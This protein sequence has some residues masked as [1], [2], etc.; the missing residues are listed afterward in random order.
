MYIFISQFDQVIPFLKATQFS[1]MKKFQLFFIMAQFIPNVFL[2]V[3]NNLQFYRIIP[4]S[5]LIFSTA[6]VLKQCKKKN[7]KINK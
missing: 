3:S 1:L 6:F 5:Q 4:L 7:T 2:F